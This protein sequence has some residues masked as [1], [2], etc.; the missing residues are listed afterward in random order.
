MNEP[1][2]HTLRLLREMRGDIQGVDRKMETLAREVR[3]VDEKVE[4]LDRKVDKNH[5]ELKDGIENLARA[6]AGEGVLARYAANHVEGRLVAIEE[7]LSALK[8][9][10]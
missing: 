6:F 3:S 8:Q 9:V 7:R 10:D 1:E 5:A 4:A 2:N